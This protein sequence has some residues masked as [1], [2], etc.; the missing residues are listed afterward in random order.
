MMSQNAGHLPHL[1]SYVIR[2]ALAEAKLITEKH[3]RDAVY[4][5][6]LT[7]ELCG[8]EGKLAAWEKELQL[9]SPGEP[10]TRSALAAMPESPDAKWIHSKSAELEARLHRIEQSSAAKPPQHPKPRKK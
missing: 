10:S 3:A 9:G 7:E 1:V 4:V 8:I 5:A 6:T 2:P